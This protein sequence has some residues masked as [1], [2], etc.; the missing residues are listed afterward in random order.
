MR[1]LLLAHYFPPDGGPGAQRPISFARRLPESGCE[2]TVVTRA[3]AR[4]RGYFDPADEAALAEVERHAEVVRAAPAEGPERLRS[5]LIEASDAAAR[6]RRPNLVLATMSPFDLWRV[7]EAVAD[8][9]GLP[10]VCD[11]RDPWALDGVQDYRSFWHWRREAREMRAMLRRA[12]GVVANTR[13]AAVAIREFEPSLGEDRLEVV[14]NGWDRDD[15]AGP[16]TE[17]PPK[18]ALRLVYGGSF[19][20]RELFARERL[21]RRLT[22]WVRYRPEP[23]RTSGRTPIHLL[24]ALRGLRARGSPAASEVRFV[25]I[26]MVDDSLRRCIRESGVEDLVQARGYCGHRELIRE[27]RAADAL[28]LTLHGLPPGRRAR[29]VPGKTYEYLASGRPI[30]AAL[31]DGDAKDLVARSPR[32]LLCDPCDEDAI[33]ARLEELHAGWK[34]GAYCESL[35]PDAFADY[36]RG[37]LCRRL[38]AFLRRVVERRR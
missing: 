33:A 7:A 26:G 22:D 32:A 24:G 10:L 2:V 12:D 9:H 11:L 6:A 16:P 5:A 4:Q 23:I 36:E 34:A 35:P 14:T 8:R 30:L 38:H 13:E 25:S 19:L 27:L 18:E 21:L 28:F 15:F 20:C 29:I 3:P 1:V 31:P 37:A 17:V